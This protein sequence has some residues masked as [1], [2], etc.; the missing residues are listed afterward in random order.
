M[1]KSRGTIFSAYSEEIVPQ[2][3]AKGAL[4]MECLANLSALG[5][6]RTW[7]LMTRNQRDGE[8]FFR[9]IHGGVLGV[10]LE[11]VQ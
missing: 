2:W 6:A 4:L 8:E 7:R 11:V 1:K 9:T 10:G 5:F 3:R